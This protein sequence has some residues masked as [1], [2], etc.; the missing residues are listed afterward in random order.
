MNNDYDKLVDKMSADDVDELGMPRILADLAE[1]ALGDEEAAAIADW[2]AATADE[3][4]PSWMVNRA[5]RIA[6]Q[7]V[8]KDAPRPSIWRKLVAALVYDN[9]LQPRV[10]GARAIAIDNPRLM[11]QA[12]GI[13]I[14]LEVGHSTIA[15]RLR[16][17]GQVTASEPDLTRAWVIAEGPSGRLETEVDD[18][19]QF[20]LDGLVSGI[21]RMEIGLAY[22][23]IEIPSV[24]I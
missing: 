6:G 17:L 13:E 3:E 8:G 12:G 7:A 11:Y 24:R 9:R 21:H 2:L 23:L 1:G 18:L 5:V 14:D 19:G 15:G 10:A 20:S 16:M 4:P 22:E